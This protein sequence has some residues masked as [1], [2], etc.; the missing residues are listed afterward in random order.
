MFLLQ[1]GA[2]G[3]SA[4]DD[5]DPGSAG[6]GGRAGA[7]P[8]GP[9]ADGSGVRRAAGAAGSAGGA[10]T[11][12]S[13]AGARGSAAGATATLAA[14][15]EPDLI[16]TASDVVTAAR[17]EYQLLRI[18]DEKLGRTPKADFPEDEMLRRAAALG[19]EHEKQVL[20]G[21][22]REH[23]RVIEID[24]VPLPYTRE[25]LI[26]AHEQTLSVLAGGAD[27]VFQATFFDGVFHG[28]SDFL[29]RTP[30][31]AYAVWD[32][33]LARRA[34]TEALLQLAAYADQLHAAGVPVAPVAT[35][36]LGDRS[37]AN[38]PLVELLPV[39]AERRR[40]VLELTAAHRAGGEPV[41]WGDDNV[42][43][44]G[45]CEYCAEQVRRHEDVLGVHRVSVPR[46]RK[47]RAEGIRT[48]TDLARSEAEPGT[49]AHRLRD[50]ARMQAGLIEPDGRVTLPD[51]PGSSGEEGDG[52]AGG[53]PSTLAYK[54]LSDHTLGTLP[55][56]D[57]GDVFFDFEGD[58]LW[59]DA[60]G[61]WG[62][63]YLFGVLEA[64]VGGAEPLFRPFLAHTRAEEGQALVA[65][66]EYIDER[67]ARYPHMRIYHYA[68][69]EKS[70]LRR[71]SLQHTLGEEAVDELLREGVLVDLY[72]VVQ[73][74]LRLSSK[75]YGLK[76][77]EPLYMGADLRTGD[78]TEGGGSMVAYA[79][80]CLARDTGQAEQAE[81]LLASLLD[82]NHYD[83]R[84]TLGLRDWLVG[85]AAE[86][87]VRLGQVPEAQP[88]ELREVEPL[89]QERK[90]DEVV[91]GRQAQAKRTGQELAPTDQALAMVAAAVGYHRREDK[92]FWW[93]HFDR[94]NA[95]TAD[96]A[97]TRD[98]FV[99]EAG[100]VVSGWRQ[101]GRQEPRRVVELTG[102]LADGSLVRPGQ[103]MY[104]MYHRP[105]PA[106]MPDD[107]RNRRSGMFGAEILQVHVG[108]ESARITF[109]EP[110][111]RGM[112]AYRELPMALTPGAP[113]KTESL[114]QALADLA[115]E[116]AEALPEV[117]AHPGL[118]VLC[119][120]PPRLA[121]LP[122][123]PPVEQGD[124][125]AAITRATADLDRSYLAVQGPPGSGK[126]YV[127]ARVIAELIDRGWKI[128]VVAQSHAVVE[129][130]LTA[131]IKAGVPAER[132]AKPVS[133]RRQVPW[134]GGTSN[135]HVTAALA[136]AGGILIGGTA[137]TMTGKAVPPGALDLV[138]IDE[139]G[140]FSLANTLAVTRATSRL[141]LLGDP[142]QLPQVSQGTHPQPV[143]TSALGWLSQHASVL[144]GE[145]GYFLAR[146]W[147]MHPALCE[148]VSDLSY[149]GQLQP[150]PVTAQRHLQAP[151]GVEC[152]FVPHT[153][154][155]TSSI[156]EATE[157][158]AQVRAHLG[159]M[160]RESA[161]A[162][163]RPLGQGDVL[164]VA[165]YNAQVQLIRDTLDAAGLTKVPV[166]TV[167]KFQGQQAPVVI[168][169]T[170]VSAVQEAPRGMEFVLNRNRVNVAIS[171][172][173]WRAV[174]VRSPDLTDVLPLRPE[175][176]ADLGAFIRLCGPA[177]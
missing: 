1:G 87:Q 100:R 141:L 106:G 71:L 126:T 171:R 39:F 14:S 75:S 53:G 28:R 177:R 95:P 48:I 102:T 163:P 89:P 105:L 133:G 151:P 66:L 136:E 58:P 86:R 150:A 42:I 153:G 173:L 174:I 169:S 35:L 61:T 76:A 70:A 149:D 63:E 109:A 168:L 155:T 25:G 148:A 73:T 137:W 43:I 90:I 154:N 116:V 111:P 9:A 167:D 19:D 79:N 77:L 60:Q 119:R 8:G 103:T 3:A 38:F 164:V 172:G 175:Q 57:E 41:A 104:R 83:C 30:E 65:F 10:G 40:R 13:A 4:V 46:R 159:L 144:P 84:S 82:Y 51:E 15:A 47:L 44:C 135:N 72:E 62:L 158:L 74:S 152:R 160:W 117:P 23:A 123:L 55:V 166:G 157:V 115:G 94:L 98:V 31:G 108:P 7:G 52:T 107:A 22:R 12:T 24:P 37:H 113:L 81:E 140:Q 122:Q 85:L 69:Y 50:Q 162:A 125:A 5:G 34:K 143:D 59:Q 78:V 54:V 17:C 32:S 170:T 97:Q 2:P 16:I 156:E 146:T 96:W 142:Q 145:L 49:V 11:P 138:V 68:A 112:S 67:R 20:A 93:A 131:A 139:A 129:N 124:Y 45:R 101:E 64:P 29:V 21:L 176:L 33:K 36:V 18:L 114:Q 27:V 6:V 80:Y 165:P 26:A 130:L 99:A 118:D 121:T 92:Q 161:T 91:R 120:H 56:P 88:E 110:L 128:G 132:V 147:R 127:G 134:R